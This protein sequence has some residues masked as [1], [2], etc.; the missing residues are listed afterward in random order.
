MLAQHR[1][2]G[3][4]EGPAEFVSNDSDADLLPGILVGA[5]RL[6]DLANTWIL[7]PQGPRAARRVLISWYALARGPAQL[8]SGA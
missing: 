7:T 8:A 5:A 6:L 3:L 4:R 2:R 1:T